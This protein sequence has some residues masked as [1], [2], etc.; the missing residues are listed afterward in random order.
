MD[1][2]YKFAGTIGYGDSYLEFLVRHFK[3]FKLH[4][5]LLDAAA[6]VGARSGKGPSYGN[7]IG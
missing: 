4:A 7:K 5:I 6:A 2:K 3:V 1:Q